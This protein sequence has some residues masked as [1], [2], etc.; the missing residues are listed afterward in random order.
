MIPLF[1]K[2]RLS[3]HN[4]LLWSVFHA[5]VLLKATLTL[6][7]GGQ[8]YP[9]KR[10][11][12]S[13][14]CPKHNKTFLWVG[15]TG[16]FLPPKLGSNQQNATNHLLANTRPCCL[17][18]PPDNKKPTSRWVGTHTPP[19]LFQHSRSHQPCGGYGGTPSRIVKQ[20]LT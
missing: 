2:L 5:Y 15:R 7:S 12:L 1:F 3:S 13:E 6:Y 4:N 17:Y 9:A 10:A 16:A 14:C 8:L 18:E 20:H 11:R 19:C